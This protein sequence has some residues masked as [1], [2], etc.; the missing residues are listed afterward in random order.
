LGANLFSWIRSLTLAERRTLLACF[1][2]WALDAFD[3]QVY[4]FTI[5]TLFSLWS[6][7]KGQAGILA[8]VTLVVSA[9][10]GWAAGTL[11]DRFGRLRVLQI[12]I[13][14]YALF[15][16]LSGLTNNFQQLFICRALQGL[17][18]GGEWAAGSVLIGEVIRPEYRGRAVGTVQSGWAVGWGAAALL[19]SLL[20]SVMP[21]EFAWRTL[22]GLG[23]LPALLVFWMRRYVHESPRFLERRESVRKNGGA[24]V[25]FSIFQPKYLSATTR[26]ALLAIGL[27]GGYNTVSVWLP[28][29]LKDE[30]RL[31]VINTGGFLLVLISGAFCGFLTGAH[32]A[33][34]IGRKRTFMVSSVGTVVMLVLYMLLPVSNEVMLFLGFPLGFFANAAFAPMGAFMTEMYPTAVR[35]TGQGFCY[36]AGRGIGAVFPALVGF[37]GTRIPL[38]EAIGILSISAYG[39]AV[40]ALL[41]LPETRGRILDTLEPEQTRV[42]DLPESSEAF[43]GKF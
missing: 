17:G 27:Q 13:V 3:V 24:Q 41:T 30:R 20:F 6:I 40:L 1:G 34:R 28:T 39:L 37:L 22:F 9:F 7:S 10:G 16:F 26:V 12:T 32:L 15:T 42:L 19:Y 21:A 14:W 23:L 38:G 36:N 35:A 8:T 4:S 5:P 43:P 11:C 25:W 31:S 2:G 33:D 18:F 29:F